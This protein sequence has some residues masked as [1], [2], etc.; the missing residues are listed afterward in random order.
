MDLLRLNTLKATFLTLKRYD[1]H[2]RPLYSPPPAGVKG[3][4]GRQSADKRRGTGSICLPAL[5]MLMS[6]LQTRFS[7]KNLLMKENE[8]SSW[9]NKSTFQD[10][11]WKDT[12]VACNITLRIVVLF[13]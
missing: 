4:R 10:H 6:S 5:S 11:L 13:I 12:V 9:A 7:A 1:K 3:G 2:H 8:F